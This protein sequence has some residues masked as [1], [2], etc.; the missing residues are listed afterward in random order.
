MDLTNGCQIFVKAIVIIGHMP[1][2][3]LL[4]L[5]ADNASQLIVINSPVEFFR[6]EIA[7]FQITINNEPGHLIHG[8]QSIPIGRRY[9]RDILCH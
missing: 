8:Q 2:M 3:V 5:S 1:L 9:G 6:D 4:K 7:K